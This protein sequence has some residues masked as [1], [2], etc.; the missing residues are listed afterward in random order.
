MCVCLILL[1]EPKNST[2]DIRPVQMR[3]QDKSAWIC[4]LLLLSS[5][6]LNNV[7]MSFFNCTRLT[8]VYTSI[9][10]FICFSF[11]GGSSLN[12]DSQTSLSPGIV[13]SAG[14]GSPLGSPPGGALPQRLLGRASRGGPVQIP[15]QDSLP[16]AR[17]VSLLC[18]CI[19]PASLVKSVLESINCF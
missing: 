19:L 2:E 15:E 9:T 13:T 12:R 6:K 5:G 10:P 4:C 8:L 1:A 16:P 3:R 11:R 14:P 17:C 7:C 18:L